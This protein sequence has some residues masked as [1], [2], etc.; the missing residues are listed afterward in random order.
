MKISKKWLDEGLGGL[1]YCTNSANFNTTFFLV[2]IAI[3]IYNIKAT[4]GKCLCI[5]FHHVIYP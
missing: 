4:L 5:L 3:L 2:F 1:G